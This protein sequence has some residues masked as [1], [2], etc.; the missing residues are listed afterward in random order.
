MKKWKSAISAVG[1]SAAVISGGHGVTRSATAADDPIKV[2]F[3]LTLSGGGSVLGK[4]LQQGANLA[5][6]HLGG[7]F[8]GRDV[9]FIFEDSQRKP[10]I[11]KQAAEKLVRSD[12]VD[13]VV[14]ATFANVLLAMANSVTRRKKLL[15][16]P[17]AAP[18][19]LA[20]KKCTPYF[21]SVPFQND[22]SSEAMGQ[23]L[24]NAGVKTAYILAPN[25]QA[26]RD[27]LA[28]FKR[29]FKGKLLGE[30]YT[31]FEQT[32]FSAELTAL[33]AEKPEAVFVFYPGGLGIQFV[34][35]YAQ[36][37]LIDQIPLYT[38]FVVN[39]ATLPAIGDAAKGVLSAGHWAI[40]LPNAANKK[41]VDGYRAKFG[42]TPSEFA[43]QGYDTVNLIASAVAKT[44]GDVS[45]VEAL[46]AALK[47]AGF[48]SVRGDF[49]F[50]T[51]QFPIHD[52]YLLEVDVDSETGE[53]AVL[54]RDVI[55]EDMP[56]SYAGQCTY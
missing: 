37:G 17:N 16:T 30:V 11:G 52:Q 24:T 47:L 40:N 20:G 9:E 1:V 8:A 56:D 35:Q 44:G 5:L 46:R 6:D 28:G 19:P 14:G 39:G 49:R 22:Q 54:A 33:A 7:K 3:V 31:P 43:S 32:D 4:E 25:Y 45:D 51:N 34:K 38:A 42:S 26:G 27:L 12:K 48:E 50:N 21:F 15:I 23:Y 53:L 10:D 55:I 41:F 13:F 29:R 18:A 2:G 36:A